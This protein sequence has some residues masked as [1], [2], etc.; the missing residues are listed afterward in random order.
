M[1]NNYIK[2]NGR[3]LQIDD[4]IYISEVLID[5][6]ET[7]PYTS[8]IVYYFDILYACKTRVRLEYD[9]ESLALKDKEMLEKCLNYIDIMNEENL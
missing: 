9:D 1:E 4:I 7:S 6:H 2:L 5:A 3:T 8:R